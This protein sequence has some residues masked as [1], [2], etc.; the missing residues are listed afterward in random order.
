MQMMAENDDGQLA[1]ER[2]AKHKQYAAPAIAVTCDSC[3]AGMLEGLARGASDLLI[4]ANTLEVSM[5]ADGEPQKL[6][7]GA[8]ATVYAGRMGRQAVAIKA[9][10]VPGDLDMNDPLVVSVRK[11]VRHMCTA[12]STRS[13]RQCLV[14]PVTCRSP[15]SCASA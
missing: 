1:G 15:T 8:T 14:W 9:I 5:G 4:S 13:S 3:A 7:S 12:A 11:E 10:K 2:V 6:S